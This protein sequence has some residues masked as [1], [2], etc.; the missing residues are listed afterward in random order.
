MA[1]CWVRAF[2]AS[3]SANRAGMLSTGIETLAP[4][5]QAELVVEVWPLPPPPA[6][7]KDGE[8]LL[9]SPTPGVRLKVGSRASSLI[10]RLPEAEA[11]RAW[12]SRM[13]GRRPSRS[14]GMVA[15]TGGAASST[16]VTVRLP[17]ESIPRPTRISRLRRDVAN[18]ASR[19]ATRAWVPARS[20]SARSDSEVAIRPALAFLTE[21]S[22][23]EALMRSVCRASSS[24]TARPRASK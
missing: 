18:W 16:G 3:M 13:S 20:D 4:I 19:L 12:A 23:S 9:D 5:D 24:C 10:F 1:A 8:T 14:P 11:N 17:T 22:R 15:G 2:W 21:K 6:K 7:G